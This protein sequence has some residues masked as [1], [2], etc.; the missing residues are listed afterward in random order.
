[1]NWPAMNLVKSNFFVLTGG[2][3]GGKSTLMCRL[4]QLGFKYIDETARPII[5]ER[6]QHGLTPRPSAREFAVRIFQ[7]DMQNFFDHIHQSEIIFFDRSFLDGAAMIYDADR[8][9]Y[10]GNKKYTG[11]A[12]V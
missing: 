4:E 9:Y 8:E 5:R 2:P 6:L 3:G 7:R 1:M 10:H 12:S 11:H